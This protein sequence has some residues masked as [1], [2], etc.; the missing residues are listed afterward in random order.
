[1][2]SS[3]LNGKPTYRIAKFKPN[4]ESEVFQS[5]FILENAT[6]KLEREKC[7]IQLKLVWTIILLVGVG[8]FFF[9]P[10]SIE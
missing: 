5:M 9:D 6:K 8:L 2:C 1:M 10:A 7:T 3:D 4:F